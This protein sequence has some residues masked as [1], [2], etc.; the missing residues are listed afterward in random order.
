MGVELVDDEND[1]VGHRFDVFEARIRAT[2]GQKPLHAL[3]DVRDVLDAFAQ[4]RVVDLIE[5]AARLLEA[6]RQRPFGVHELGADDVQ[7]VVEQR[8]ILEDHAMHVDEGRRFGGHFFVFETIGERRELL[9]DRGDRHAQA[10][11]LAANRRFVDEKLR[12]FQVGGRKKEHRPAG[13][14]RIGRQARKKG[15][16][17]RGLD[18]GLRRLVDDALGGDGKRFAHLSAS[19]ARGINRVRRSGSRKVRRCGAGRSLRRGRR[20][21]RR[22]RCP[23][24]EP[25]S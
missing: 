5:F 9:V 21:R 23:W 15:G 8:R 7:R 2:A 3:Y 22:A 25:S 18:G 16:R 12:N 17:R 14:A 20:R 24:A 6:Q 11:A 1:L 4:V 13:H 10:L 19:F